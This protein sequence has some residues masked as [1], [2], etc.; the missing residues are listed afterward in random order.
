MIEVE[1]KFRLGKDAAAGQIRQKLSAYPS[2]ITDQVDEVFLQGI[3]S[4]SDFKP[5]MPVLR[6]RSSNNTVTMTFKKTINTEGN[7]L[8]LETTLGDSETTTAILNELGFTRVT[9]V[10]KTREEFD[11]EDMKV[12]LDTVENLGKFV[13][14]EVL[15]DESM[16][17][18]AE[19][20]ILETAQ[21]LGLSEQ[22]I[23]TKKYDYLLS[24]LSS[25][26]K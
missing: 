1:R 24:H 9:R 7:A 12:A 18:Q 6:L 3:A 11:L 22:D 13:E 21:S 5:G 19:K 16:Q 14:I 20:K 15:T 26:A 2:T 25:Q 10:H 8:E 17:K 23:E 4:F